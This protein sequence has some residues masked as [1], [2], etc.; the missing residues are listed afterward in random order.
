MLTAGLMTER[1]T[2]LEAE[3]VVNDLGEQHSTWTEKL[4]TWAQVKLA[5]GTRDDQSGNVVLTQSVQLWV[6]WRSELHD[7][8]RFRYQGQLYAINVFKPSYTD[9]SIEVKGYRIDT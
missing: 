7:R 2:W 9:G 4:S 8:M 1:V 6:R 3:T 5:D